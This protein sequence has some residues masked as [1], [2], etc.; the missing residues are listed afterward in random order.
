MIVFFYV[1]KE[2]IMRQVL[3]DEAYL[4]LEDGTIFKGLSFGSIGDVTG[5]LVF[6]TG[7][8]GYLETLTDPSYHGQI[9]IQ[10]FPL[11]GNYG[12]IPDDFE[13]DSARVKAYI[14]KY[15]SD[16]PSNFR[17]GGNIDAFLKK[18][19]V[20]GLYGIDTRE[21]TK[22]IRKNGV[23]CGKITACPPTEKD[24]TEAQEYSIKNAVAAASRA[25]AKLSEGKRR[26]ALMDFGAKRS[27]ARELALRGC[28]VWSFPYNATA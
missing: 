12:V 27:I 24:R 13:S 21:L 10:T 1:I 22:I 25:G 7:M 26:V 20:V 11:I 15:P 17:S 5:E 2:F 3:R 16:N 23:I 14:V 8:T 28:E 9:V 18:S 6:T 4:I 19:G